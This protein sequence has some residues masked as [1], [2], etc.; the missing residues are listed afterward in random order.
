MKLAARTIFLNVAHNLSQRLRHHCNLFDIQSKL[1]LSA[2]FVVE[3]GEVDKGTGSGD[4][5]DDD[6]ISHKKKKRRRHSSG[7]LT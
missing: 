6:Q 5:D 3:D 4:D 7:Y 1:P 2:G